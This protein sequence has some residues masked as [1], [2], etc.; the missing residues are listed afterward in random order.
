M[1]KISVIGPAA[2]LDLG[3]EGGL[4]EDEVLSLERYNR[5]FRLQLVE[6]RLEIDG[7]AFLEP[8]PDRS[9]RDPA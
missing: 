2:K 7:A 9:D 1:P 6:R 3:D 5:L 4:R 8:G